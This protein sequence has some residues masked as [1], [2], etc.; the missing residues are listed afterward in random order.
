MDGYSPDEK[1]FNLQLIIQKLEEELLLYRNGTTATELLELIHEKDVEIETWRAKCEEKDEKLK[2]LA[3]TSGD[4]LLNYERLQEDLQQKDHEK[5][6]LEDICKRMQDEYQVVEGK[7]QETKREL[8]ALGEVLTSK[9][10][11][12]GTLRL[13]VWEQ[14]QLITKL[15]ESQFNL[16]QQ[17]EQASNE[18]NSLKAM[19]SEEIQRLTTSLEDCQAVVTRKEQDI[20]ELKVDITKWKGYVEEQDRSIEKLQKRCATLVAEKSE[21]L[22]ALDIERQEMINHV[23]QFRESMSNNLNQRDEMIRKKDD[24]IRDV[25]LIFLLWF[26][27]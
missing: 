21:K 18:H 12:I 2:R 4:V 7:F 15:E 24:K 1:V 5:Y 19:E 27:C 8:Q 26:C 9:D 16:Q 22:R 13:E 6:R 25:S 10:D 17:L 3:K 23:Q 20:Q 14:K 11:S